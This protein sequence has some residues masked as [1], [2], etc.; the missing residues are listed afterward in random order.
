MLSIT[1]EGRYR[2]SLLRYAER[3]GVIQAAIKYHRNRQFIYRLR[4]RYDGTIQSLLPKS[5]R[6]HSHPAQH[7]PA[8]IRLI[9]NMHRRHPH[10]G[11][12]VFWARYPGEKVQIDV[13]VVP[14]ACIVGEARRHH[15]RMYQYTAID[16]CTR[17]RYLAAFPE[18]ST[19][20]S[21]QFLQQLVRHFPFPIR[22]VQTDNGFEFTK[23][24]GKVPEDDLTLFEEQLKAFHIKHHKIRPYT[25]RH[26]GKV[27]RSHR[28]DNEYFYARHT[29]FSFADF[30]QQL[31]V[32]NREYNRFPMKPLGWKSP[33]EVLDSY[34]M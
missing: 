31:A 4:W 29:F 1:Q 2:L 12:V 25:P 8:E 20:A 32:R 11:L 27:E 14:A 26:N 28:K 5:R 10:D 22:E 15:Q 6:P 18:Q 34:S 24:F 16:E 13:K 9:R 23:R 33:K 3:H 17:Y 7:T 21:M 19:Y 30:K